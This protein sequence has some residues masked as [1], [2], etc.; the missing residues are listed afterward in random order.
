MYTTHKG[1]SRMYE[2]SCKELDFLVNAV[3]NNEAVTGARMMGGG[4]G[5]CTINLVKEE[6]IE[7]L[8]ATIRPAYENE[9][10]LPLTYYIASIEDGAGIVPDI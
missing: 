7:E 3:E 6:K 5:G 8:I 2:V 10:K 4:F 1:L 9:M